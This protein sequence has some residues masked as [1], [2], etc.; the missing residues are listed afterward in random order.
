MGG[1]AR[2]LV[3]VFVLATASYALPVVSSTAAPEVARDWEPRLLAS[4]EIDWVRYTPDG[5]HAIVGES[6]ALTAIPI[7]GGLS[8][9]LGSSDG[10]RESVLVLNDSSAALVRDGGSLYLATIATGGRRLLTDGVGRKFA[11]TDDDKWCVAE[12]DAGL[13]KIEISTGVVED[14]PGVPGWL[15]S[16]SSDLDTVA[17]EVMYL[18]ALAEDE[19]EVRS[20]NLDSGVDRFIGMA[21]SLAGSDESPVLRVASQPRLAVFA[22]DGGQAAAFRIYSIEPWEL[23]HSRGYTSIHLTS[24]GTTLLATDVSR[25]G[26][27]VYGV[28]LETEDI[29]LFGRSFEGGTTG[30]GLQVADDERF[31]SATMSDVDMLRTEAYVYDVATHSALSLGE[32]TATV[33]GLGNSFLGDAPRLLI[34]NYDDRSFMPTGM[35]SVTVTGADP[36]PWPAH[37]TRDSYVPAYSVGDIAYVLGDVG[38]YRLNTDGSDPTLV[39]SPV[40]Q[41]GSPDSLIFSPAG[42][43]L[44]YTDHAL[45]GH[46][47]NVWLLRI[48]P[49]FD[50]CAGSGVITG[51][52]GNDHIVGTEGDDIIKGLAGD[53]VIDG[54]G[55]N[56]FICGDDGDDRLIGGDGDD[57]IFGGSGADAV[58]GGRGRDVIQGGLGPDNL[59]G[60]RGGDVIYGGDGADAIRGHGGPDRLYGDAGD[61]QISGGGGADT[62]LGGE[63]ADAL[64]GNAGPDTVKSVAGDNVV[65]GG[66]GRDTLY[67]GSGDDVINGAAGNDSLVSTLGADTLDGGDGDDI[68]HLGS[69]GPDGIGGPGNDT[70]TWGGPFWVDPPTVWGGPGNDTIGSTGSWPPACGVVRGGTG[71]DTVYCGSEGRMFGGDGSDQLHGGLHQ[72]GGAGDDELFM[73][74][75]SSHVPGRTQHGG[76]GHDRISG[77]DAA[78]QHGGSGNDSLT[79]EFFTTVQ[80]GG[81]GADVLSSALIQYGKKGNDTLSDFETGYGGHG[82]DTLNGDFRSN[83]LYGGAGD[84]VLSGGGGDDQLFGGPGID[85]LDGGNGNDTCTDEGVTTPC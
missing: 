3:V 40:L 42:D 24:D 25:G 72:Y 77:E 46:I 56:D 9:S 55:G 8:V 49:E 76:P 18:A 13:V 26:A 82:A 28:D 1:K 19:F 11:L 6:G 70:I 57:T 29:V 65:N 33:G 34:R 23:M 45:S 21:P 59:V 51:T 39:S 27:D 67:G 2:R 20:L 54:K 44:I 78:R 81:T 71:D 41:G 48:A 5:A 10:T 12:A 43:S 62:I 17:N 32:L 61:D 15:H 22:F 79:G 60:G 68:L 84:D 38:V 4:G 74:V 36:K 58:R 30:A 37:V 80:V 31:A 7:A 52:D 47:G 35:F 83:V 53:D 64:S 63:G 85:I 75:L 73:P 50:P 69:E 14:I 16:R 66:P